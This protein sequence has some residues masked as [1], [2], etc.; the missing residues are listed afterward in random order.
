MPEQLEQLLAP[1][2][3]SSLFSCVWAPLGV[4]LNNQRIDTPDHPAVISSD[5]NP[6]RTTDE[7]N[8]HR[9]VGR[10]DVMVSQET[11]AP[12]KREKDIK[13]A[14]PSPN[15][16]VELGTLTETTS[17]TSSY[18]TLSRESSQP[19]WTPETTPVVLWG[20]HTEW[21]PLGSP[22][23]SR[24]DSHRFLSDDQELMDVPVIAFGKFELIV[25]SA[26]TL[27]SAGY[28]DT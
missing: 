27:T 14:D 5:Y 13:S 16:G 1:A 7:V 11:K 18:C 19:K 20:T 21:R 22:I 23:S 4:P 17:T 24:N 8:Q 9:F 3:Y 26:S 25:T 10:L 6:F 12:K 28:E 15:F 2:V